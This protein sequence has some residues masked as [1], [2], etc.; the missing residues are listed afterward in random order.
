MKLRRR[1]DGPRT[2]GGAAIDSPEG[3]LA[4]QT[5]V[6]IG[7]SSGIG[8]ETAR[9][10]RA[11]GAGLVITA[12]DPDPLHRAGLELEAGIAALDPLD[13]DRLTRFFG[14]LSAPVDHVA[15]AALGHRDTR[16]EGLDA[17]TARRGLDA[18][19]LVPL[20]VARNAAGRLRDGGTLLF[21]GGGA[22]GGGR[23][24]GP[25]VSAALPALTASLA[26]ELP[27]IRVNLISGVPASPA[28][29][30]AAEIAALAVHL[31]TNGA[32]T[33]ATLEVGRVRDLVT[34]AN[35]SAR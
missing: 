11:A 18:Q 34:G 10:A 21:L 35:A 30:A 19:L 17:D 9:R 16:L 6:V 15:L 24:L 32:L 13:F 33:G 1:D 8:L 29:S 7:G 4:G 12:T 25:V 28:P 20:Q 26:L 2:Q 27:G 5:V 23:S 31:M 22:A 3:L 14:A